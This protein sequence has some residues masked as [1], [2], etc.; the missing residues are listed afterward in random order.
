MSEYST[1]KTLS[2]SA[3]CESAKNVARES[4]NKTE[5]YVQYMPDD[6]PSTHSWP[7]KSK[8]MQYVLY[9]TYQGIYELENGDMVNGVF[10]TH[11]KTHLKY[12][13]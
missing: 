1:T 7:P 13:K 12:L 2:L 8:I 10:S 3:L 11:L 4:S 6:W 5:I 9:E